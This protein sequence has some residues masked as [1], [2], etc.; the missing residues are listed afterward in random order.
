MLRTHRTVI[1]SALV[2]SSWVT[3]A[4]CASSKQDRRA[5]AQV[6]PAVAA[7]PK[8]PTYTEETTI[9]TE[10]RTDLDQGS[11][12]GQMSQPGQVNPSRSMN[13]AANPPAGSTCN[14]ACVSEPSSQT[15][16]G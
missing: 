14:C 9:R 1:L 13:P 5:S 10:K 4:G 15:P 11:Q 7:A 2:I 16:E 8:T 12:A 3:M 6:T